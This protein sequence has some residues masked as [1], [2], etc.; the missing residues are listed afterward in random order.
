MSTG[1]RV[2]LLILSLLGVGIVLLTT[3]K[4]GA[5][6]SPDSVSYISAARN[7]AAGRGLATFNDAPLVAWPPLF[8]ALLAGIKVLLGIDPLLSV[9]V[10]NAL[11]FGLIVWLSGVLCFRHLSSSFLTVLL[12][13]TSVLLAIPLLATAR[14]AW[15]EPLFIACVLLSLIWAESYAERGDA[16]SLALISVAASTASLSRYIGVTVIIA[17]A[18]V[19]AFSTKVNLRTRLVHLCAFLLISV[20]PLAIW[21][22]RNYVVSGTPMGARS[23]SQLSFI[24][25]LSS[26]FYTLPAWYLPSRVIQ[27]RSTL[28]LLCIAIVLVTTVAARTNWHSVKARLS[29]LAPALVF[30]AT[31]ILILLTLAT[32]T[33]HDRIDD[34]LLSPLYIPLVLLLFVLAESVVD[35]LRPRFARWFVKAVLLTGVATWLVYLGAV[36]SQDITSSVANGAG[37][38][39][40]NTWKESE[41]IEFLLQEQRVGEYSYYSNAP[42][43]LYILTG[44]PA[45]FSPRKTAYNSAET[46]SEAKDL[47]GVWPEQ[48]PAKLVWFDTTNRDYL[49][50]VKELEMIAEFEP[51]LR[52]SDATIYVVSKEGDD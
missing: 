3:S 27:H 4:Y 45:Q 16:G 50:T 40:T 7:L 44:L 20:A 15:S 41:T 13:V 12:G 38:Y 46:L 14:M 47:L 29:L 52:L 39:H 25:N 21:I 24:Q 43:A 33:A 9:R 1:Q 17:G 31:Y 28:A 6:L 32:I 2:A 11:L 23:P 19:I 37:G 48:E 22:S 35:L 34:R 49:F 10:V 36:A 26:T 5:G 18:I 51:I 30:A 8:P 42:D